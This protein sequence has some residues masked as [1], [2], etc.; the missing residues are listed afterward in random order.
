MTMFVIMCV[1]YGGTSMNISLTPDLEQFVKVQLDT[2]LYNNSSEVMRAA[3]R[4]LKEH[5]E[6]HQARINQLNI[7][8]A[9][10]LEQLKSGQVMTGEQA[11]ARIKAK[12][13][14]TMKT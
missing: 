2:G 3:L 7:E 14:V 11:L 12:K 1:R 9:R 10:G 4:L 5:D 8:I 13:S 6:L